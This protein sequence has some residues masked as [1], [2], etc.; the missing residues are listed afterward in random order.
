[1]LNKKVLQ[2]TLGMH[3]SSKSS[4]YQEKPLAFLR[5][6]ENEELQQHFHTEQQDP[7]MVPFL[8]SG[9]I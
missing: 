9:H 3:Q 8:Y 5:S 1:M 2:L 4:S 6:V 7:Q